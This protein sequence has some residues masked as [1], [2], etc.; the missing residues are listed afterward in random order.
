MCDLWNEFELKKPP[1][2]TV[3]IPNKNAPNVRRL[4][5]A[6]QQYFRR[7]RHQEVEFA[8]TS[9]LLGRL[10]ARR[11]NS[12]HGMIGFR[13]IVKCNTATCRLLRIDLTRELEL[14]HGSLPDFVLNS[15]D[16]IE[17]PTQNNF[18]YVL[19]R[20]LNTHGVYERIRACCLQ[21]AEYFS[22]L[23]RNNFF[24]DTC[25]LLL[26]VL[27]KLYSLS[28]LL[29]NK[30]VE[31]YNQLRPMREK[32]PL[33]EKSVHYNINMPEKLEKFLDHQTLNVSSAEGTVFKDDT[34][35]TVSST[36]SLTAVRPVKPKQMLKPLDLGTEVSRPT[37][38]SPQTK[39]FN[40]DVELATVE[41]TKRF[42]HNENVSR[43]QS[44]KQ[45]VTKDI[46]PH[47]WI[48]A[49]RLFER[50]LLSNDHKKALSIFRKFI[51]NKIS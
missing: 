13:A 5:T 47:E 17:M 32:F 50:K 3:T 9:A 41:T 16:T 7:H 11:K 43:K 48:G 6:I 4:Q 39:T 42:I 28:A 46:M 34:S 36:K 29:G 40:A 21:A 37:N 44:L 23:M 12:F 33:S 49:T 18:D 35:V 30:C 1:Q 2:L 25:T 20:L 14:F 31:L 19:I 24:M 45:S 22:K 8:E 38:P 10:M 26:A 27:A 51:V 15:A